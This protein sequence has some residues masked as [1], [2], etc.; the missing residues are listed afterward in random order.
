MAVTLAQAEKNQTDP[1]VKSA[2]QIA[3]ATSNVW[4]RLCFE[5]IQGNAFAY[6]KDKVLPGTAFRTVNEA[7]V[8]D[9]GVVNSDVERLVIMGGDATVDRFIQQTYSDNIKIKIADQMAMKIESLQA[10]FA[11]Y[12]FHGDVIANPK[13]F[14]GLRKRLV[15]DQVIDSAKP[16]TDEGFLSELDDL[17]DAADADVVYMPRALRTPLKALFRKA[18]GAEYVV[19]E[20][21]GKRELTW[22][23][24]PIIDPG[25]TFDKRQI[26][27]VDATAGGDMYAVK[28][29]RSD[30]EEG[31]LGINNGGLIVDPPKLMEGRPAYI[32]RIEMY[33]GLVVQGGNAAARL[34]GVKK[35]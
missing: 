7:Y 10:T 26:L 13:G 20:I 22:N 18:G 34:R 14:D 28:F 12:F 1:F 8:E 21:T 2:Y 17:I 30:S 35:Q 23:G 11:E 4:D 9:T 5:G 16:V 27:P 19:S 6:D 31:V 33:A 3:V 24:I 15:G 29:A 25:K 32:G